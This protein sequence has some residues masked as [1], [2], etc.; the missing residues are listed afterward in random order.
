VVLMEFPDLDTAE[1]WYNSA[2]YQKI[3]HLRTG[4][5]I[6]DLILVDQVE[7]GFTSAAWAQQVRAAIAAG[8]DGAA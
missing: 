3:L 1:K 2:E 7:A 6:D 8:P 5:T 4:N